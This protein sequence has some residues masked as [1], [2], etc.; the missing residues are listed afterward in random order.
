M[1]DFSRQELT[2]D[3]CLGTN[4]GTSK[5]GK[6]P[7][8]SSL[9]YAALPGQITGPSFFHCAF[10]EL[11]FS[12]VSQSGPSGRRENE[13]AALKWADG[14]LQGL[15]NNNKFRNSVLLHVAVS[16]AADQQSSQALLPGGSPITLE[17]YGAYLLVM[18]LPIS[19]VLA[20]Q[21]ICINADCSIEV[22]TSELAWLP[23]HP[24][25]ADRSALQ[26]C[27]GLLGISGDMRTGRCR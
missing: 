12:G 18:M 8:S 24:C 20:A 26:R 7:M 13:L 5:Q 16:F 17:T 21:N 19:Q 6:Y 27:L 3:A 25:S 10:Q 15:M 4:S 2:V 23:E 14:L 22:L 9:L 11:R 1:L